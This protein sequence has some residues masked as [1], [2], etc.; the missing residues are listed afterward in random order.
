M[1]VDMVKYAREKKYISTFS[2]LLYII[3]Y[4][5]AYCNIA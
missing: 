5:H 3:G 4:M 2:L 1:Y